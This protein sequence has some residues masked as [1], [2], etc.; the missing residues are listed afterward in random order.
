MTRGPLTRERLA[1]ILAV[2]LLTTATIVGGLSFGASADQGWAPVIVMPGDR[3]LSPQR[4]QAPAAKAERPA[5]VAKAAPIDSSPARRPAAP[6]IQP[7]S[8]DPAAAGPVPVDVAASEASKGTSQ[9]AAAPQPAPAPAAKAP[10]TEGTAAQQY[11]ANIADAAADAR[12]AWQKKVLAE[13]QQEVE[14]R[15]AKLDAKIAEYQ[16]WLARRDEFSKKA[17]ASL[18]S[19]YSRMRPDAAASQLVKM[20]EETAA[21]V[22]LKLDPR[23]ASTILNEIP[24]P[25]A[26]RLTGT[27]SG[28]AR[29][30]TDKK[31]S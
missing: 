6:A 3:A 12:F 11:C 28:A 15:I 17:Q 29:T 23:I 9:P 18:V 31:K 26:A 25:Q 20:D 8:A 22:L 24:A 30:S 1:E 19:I 27:I 5:R 10:V 4:V 14:K 2:L 7:D 16:K 13:A 21:A